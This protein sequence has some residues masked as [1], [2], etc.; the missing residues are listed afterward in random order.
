MLVVAKITIAIAHKY[1]C[2]WGFRY[3]I[4]L[5]EI[6]SLGKECINADGLVTIK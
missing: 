2:E 6:L 3:S 1:S 5:I 4:I